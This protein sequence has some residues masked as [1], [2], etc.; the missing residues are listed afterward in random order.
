MAK[1]KGIARTS[2]EAKRRGAKIIP[3]LSLKTMVK[4]DKEA[5]VVFSKASAQPG[6]IAWMGPCVGG[7]R[8]VCYFDENMDPSDCRSQSC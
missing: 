6:D 4:A 2:A 8:I 3:K 1:S 5:G 7:R